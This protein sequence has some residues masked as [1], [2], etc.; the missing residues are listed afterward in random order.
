MK[1]LRRARVLA[2]LMGSAA[3]A[4][5]L[6][7]NSASQ[8]EL[9]RLRGIGPEVSQRILDARRERPFADWPDAMQRLK[10]LGPATA[11]RWSQQGLTVQGQAYA[12][13]PPSAASAASR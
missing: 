4:A 1:P 5:A 6:D 13:A 3:C 7:L 9:E 11:R 12:A 8:A 2:L 10:G